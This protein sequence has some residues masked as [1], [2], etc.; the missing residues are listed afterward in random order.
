MEHAKLAG[1]QTFPLGGAILE[2][3]NSQEYETG[4]WRV[5]RPVVDMERCT[6]CML[7][8]IFCPDSAVVVARERLQ[9][10]DLSHCKGCGICATEC[11]ARCIS[12]VAEASTGEET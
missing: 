11:P 9:G 2:P 6:H 12:M 10:F 5:T 4:G 7:C 3:G 1:W 8:W